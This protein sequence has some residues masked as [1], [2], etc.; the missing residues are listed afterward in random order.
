MLKSFYI[1]FKT[2][3]HKYVYRIYSGC[4]PRLSTGPRAVLRGLSIVSVCFAGVGNN[5]PEAHGCIAALQALGMVRISDD[6]IGND[7][8]IVLMWVG[9]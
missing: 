6:K 8:Y 1:L 5:T 9:D 2:E 7:T 3:E 4:S